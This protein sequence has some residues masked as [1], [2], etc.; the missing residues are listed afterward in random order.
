MSNSSVF[1]P[2]RDAYCGS[3]ACSASMNAA[4][5]RLGDDVQ[6]EGRLTGRFGAVH[7]DDAAARDAA[8]SERDVQGQGA[9]R[10]DVDVLSLH[11][12]ETHDRPLSVG[13][14][15]LSERC[16]QC[17]IPLRRHRLTPLVTGRS[18][19]PPAHFHDRLDSVDGTTC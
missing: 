9:G 11:V 7:L 14:L 1:T 15:D 5:L 19:T 8:D 2:M 13:S 10:D 4:T 16:L 3:S 6:G 12:A 17:P 18:S